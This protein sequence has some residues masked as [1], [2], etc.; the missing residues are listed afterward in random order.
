MS[1]KLTDVLKRVRPN[2][3]IIEDKNRYYEELYAPNKLPNL[4][5]LLNRIIDDNYQKTI[6]VLSKDHS[7]PYFRDMIIGDAEPAFFY[8]D[9]TLKTTIREYPVRKIFEEAKAVKIYNNFLYI[10]YEL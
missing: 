8:Y 1:S 3:R 4:Y 2:M 9:D 7:W 5:P 10:A 6:V